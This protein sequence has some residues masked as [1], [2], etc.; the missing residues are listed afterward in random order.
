[1]SSIRK[2]E[3][4]ADRCSQSVIVQLTC[5]GLPGNYACALSNIKPNKDNDCRYLVIKISLLIFFYFQ[6][7]TN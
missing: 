6:K 3:T 4:L 2:L 1:M 7:Q 5:T